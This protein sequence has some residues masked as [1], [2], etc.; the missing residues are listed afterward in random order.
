MLIQKG[1]VLWKSSIERKRV[2]KKRFKRE[3]A[4]EKE[5]VYYKKCI[6]RMWLNGKGEEFGSKGRVR[7]KKK[8]SCIKKKDFD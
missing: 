8:M 1:R 6:K 4:S 3:F 7:R 2:E 5:E